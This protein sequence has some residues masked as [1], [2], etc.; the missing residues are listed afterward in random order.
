MSLC[1]ISV[2]TLIEEEEKKK[3]RATLLRIRSKEIVTAENWG[4]FLEWKM[5]L[6]ITYCDC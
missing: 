1:Q 2:S 6:N 5:L 3:N 4:L